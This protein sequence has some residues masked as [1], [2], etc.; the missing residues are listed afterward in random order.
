MTNKKKVIKIQCPFERIK[1]HNTNPET[2]LYKAAIMQLIIDASNTS[3]DPRACRNERRAKEWLFSGCEDF[4]FTC[5][6]ASMEPKIVINLAKEL[7]GIHKNNTKKNMSISQKK[8]ISLKMQKSL[9]I[10]D[11]S[12]VMVSFIR[13]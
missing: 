12:S 8:I 3:K 9:K 4:Y 11:N 1:K 13:L 5:A 7:I 10:V 2:A 6:M